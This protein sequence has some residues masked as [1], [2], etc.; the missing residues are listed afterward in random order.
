MRRNYKSRTLKKT[1]KV[2][3]KKSCKKLNS[4]RPKR[5][6]LI[7]EKTSRPTLGK[8]DGGG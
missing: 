2:V 1:K 5:L 6:K 3:T 4:L 7:W 8:G